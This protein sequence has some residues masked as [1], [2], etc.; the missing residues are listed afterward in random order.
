MKKFVFF[1]TL[2]LIAVS[3]IK[4]NGTDSKGLVSFESIP[5]YIKNDELISFKISVMFSERAKPVNIDFEIW[6]GSYLIRNE[7]VSIN[8]AVE[9]LSNYY[10]SDEIK[11]TNINTKNYGGKTL[12]IYLDPDSKVSDNCKYD[13]S[14]KEATVEIPNE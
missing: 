1:T 5:I 6:D 12:T 14:F 4:E 13:K 9:N 10:I 2:I 3:C 11:V 8:N 7:S